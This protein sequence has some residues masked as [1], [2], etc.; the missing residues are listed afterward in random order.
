MDILSQFKKLPDWDRY[1][2]PELCYKEFNL[3]KPKS[4][5]FMEG[6]TYR[7]PPSDHLPP[8]KRGPAPGGVREVPTLPQLPVTLEYREETPE[9]SCSTKANVPKIE[10][11][12]PPEKRGPPPVPPL[13]HLRLPIRSPAPGGVREVPTL[14]P[15]PVT[16]EYREE[17]PESSSCS[18]EANVPKTQQLEDQS[19]PPAPHAVQDTKPSEPPRGAS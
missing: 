19:N 6:L 13:D 3:E 14:P 12:Q 7:S 11:H 2:L 18:T 15:L 1:P 17:T 5:S 4:F 10:D 8:E 9:S 16:L